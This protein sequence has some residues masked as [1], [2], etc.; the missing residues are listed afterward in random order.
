MKSKYS[1]WFVIKIYAYL[2]LAVYNLTLMAG[3]AYLVSIWNWSPYWF[4]ATFLLLG[5]T[6]KDKDE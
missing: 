5:R 1:G 2:I 4:I 6:K 3:T